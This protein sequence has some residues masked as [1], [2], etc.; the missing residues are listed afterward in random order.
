VNAAGEAEE[1]LT[2]SGESVDPAK[3]VIMGLDYI[4]SG[5]IECNCSEDVS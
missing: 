5:L 3:A 4:T 1:N 2:D